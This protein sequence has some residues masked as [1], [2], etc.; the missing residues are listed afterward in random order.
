MGI[1]LVVSVFILLSLATL[2]LKHLGER[3]LLAERDLRAASA[4]LHRQ[5]ALEWRA[6]SGRVPIDDVRMQITDSRTHT[7]QLLTAVANQSRLLQ[8]FG[9]SAGTAA[10]SSNTTSLRVAQQQYDHAVDTELNLLQTGDDAG[11][12]TQD[13]E[14]VDPAFETLT[15]ALDRQA[16]TLSHAARRAQHLSDVGVLALVLISIAAAAVLQQRWTAN[17]T[18]RS[19]E[20]ASEARYHALIEHS[21]DLVLVC[22]RAGSLTYLSP[23]LQRLLGEQ[24]PLQGQNLL[25]LLDE[26]DRRR[27]SAAVRDAR[28]EHLA[29]LDLRLHVPGGERLLELVVQDLSNDPA[30]SGIVLTAHDIT[31]RHHLQQE[32][33]HRALHDPLTGLPNRLSLARRLREVADRDAA[34]TVAPSETA[35][36][37]TT[38]P[39][40][41][42]PSTI[43]AVQA[44]ELAQSPAAALLLLDLDRFKDVNNTFGHL[45]GDQLLMQVAPR[46]RA[47]LR[48]EDVVARLDGDQF[49]VLLSDLT[50]GADALS[51]TAEEA[52]AG[53]ASK[54][55]VDGPESP[56]H[57]G[58]PGCFAREVATRLQSAL[59]EPFTITTG[60]GQI[61]LTV[62][63]SIG[64]AVHEVAQINR[65]QTA[66]KSIASMQIA[67]GRIGGIDLTALLQ[68]ADIAL[69]QA[70]QTGQKITVH[71]PT[72]NPDSGKRLDLLTDLHR[73]LHHDGDAGTDPSGQ[74]RL[75]Y[76]PKVDSRTGELLGAEALLRW[77]HPEHGLINPDLFIPLAESTGLIGPLT[78]HVLELAVSQAARWSATGHA[79]PLAVNLSA[80]N[81]MEQDL[82]NRVAATLARHDLDP[83]LLKLEVTETAVMTDP[84]RATV[85]LHALC[86]LGVAISLDDFG[87]GYTSLA[88]LRNLPLSEL[89]IDRSFITNMSINPADTTIVASVI[90]LAHNLGLSAVAE[91]VEDGY[92]LQT[93]ADYGCDVIQGYHVSR[94][95]DGVAFATW[96]ETRTLGATTAESQVRRQS[97]LHGAHP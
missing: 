84:E 45:V 5:D 11:A 67:P 37:S 75:H 85:L 10:T 60:S 73:L 83:Q 71:D 28:P 74:L 46:L 52:G 34:D 78:Q 50:P 18:R 35:S 55:G 86:D 6:I 16:T 26:D 41:T 20:R 43:G 7:A 21:A 79:V 97:A 93:L 54:H 14:V 92:T 47:V 95:L 72:M 2:H 12:T 76:Q 39:S 23:S 58:N 29:R 64:I 49:A 80:R 40:I 82:P 8:T 24:T 1:T 15:E 38:L 77:H 91:G 56:E 19:A 32:L 42:L 96:R 94:P 62:E 48:E 9:S 68:R 61:D 65:E 33:E 25:H 17:N 87:A 69:H 44:I 51:L 70:K 4:E 88:Q 63:I 81:L 30:V 36:L 89:K 90:T 66:S 59:E 57:D 27:L 53:H 22:E 31:E 13:E 3:G